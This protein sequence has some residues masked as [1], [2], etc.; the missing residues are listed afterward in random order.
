MET[1]VEHIKGFHAGCLGWM[2]MHRPN[3]QNF[4]DDV[5]VTNDCLTSLRKISGSSPLLRRDGQLQRRA[6]FVVVEQCEDQHDE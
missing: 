6:F 1:H 5:Q 4:I 3:R 2:P